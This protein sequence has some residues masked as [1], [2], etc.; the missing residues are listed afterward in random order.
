VLLGS[1]LAYE[2]AGPG[3]Y[4]EMTLVKR[5][6]Q[7]TPGLSIISIEAHEDI[8]LEEIWATLEIEG[9]GTFSIYEIT[10]STFSNT[11]QFALISIGP[12][13]F[14]HE[15]EG[16]IGVYQTSSGEAIR[17]KGYSSMADF[18]T[19]SSFAKKVGLEVRDMSHFMQQYDDVLK[20]CETWHLK[21]QPI[22]FTDANGTEHKYSI[23]LSKQ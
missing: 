10:P 6:I 23:A 15:M 16:Y 20:F 1:W 7:D 4:R 21:G 19:A 2:W 17:S 9:R 3:Y 5:A 12:Y 13:T 11:D 14:Y 18:G 22:E 8:S